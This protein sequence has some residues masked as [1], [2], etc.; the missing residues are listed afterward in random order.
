MDLKQIAEKPQ[1]LKLQLDSE[2]IIEKYGEP[3]EF[4]MY[5]RQSI[6]TY[7]KISTVE[8][9]T[10]ELINIVKDMAM[11]ND[12][13]QMLSEDDTLPLDIMLAMIEKVVAQLGKSASQTLSI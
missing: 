13:K 9:N 3:I 4:Y 12:G 2:S 6:P 8:D 1:L 10:E 7:V 11:T 5:D